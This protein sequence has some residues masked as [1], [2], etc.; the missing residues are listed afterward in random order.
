M[1]FAK[2]K[3]SGAWFNSDVLD[4][5][6]TITAAA[7]TD[8]SLTT[9]AAVDRLGYGSGEFAIVYNHTLA[10]T[11]TLTVSMT[12]MDCATPNGTYAAYATVFADEVVATGLSTADVGV[13]SLNVD[14][15]GAERYIKV[16]TC[17]D[18]SASGTDTATWTAHWVKGGADVNPV[19]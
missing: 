19:T 10:D 1:S 18:L 12:I 17:T 7:G 8:N 4:V 16:Q 14:L 5:R 2:R 3:N 9:S 15:S 6:D 13:N 11:E